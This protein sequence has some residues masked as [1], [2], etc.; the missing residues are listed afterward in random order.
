MEILDS[1]PD[2]GFLVQ[3]TDPVWLE[4]GSH[5]SKGPKVWTFSSRFL[6]NVV[7][8]QSIE[9]SLKEFF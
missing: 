4:D 3:E 9:E 5:G 2:P 1:S 7:L 8:T 6:K